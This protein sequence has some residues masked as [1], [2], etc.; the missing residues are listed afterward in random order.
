MFLERLAVGAGH[1]VEQIALGGK[2]STAS[3][4]H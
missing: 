1:V 2:V 3:W 4:C